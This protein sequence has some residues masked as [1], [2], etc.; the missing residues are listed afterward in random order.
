M[1]L[2]IS[3]YMVKDYSNA[4]DPR[5]QS[6]IDASFTHRIA[7]P[8][9][10]HQNERI[11]LSTEEMVEVRE[12][13]CGLIFLR[14][15]WARLGFISSATIVD[16]GFR[17]SLTMSLFNSAGHSIRI[18]PRESIWALVILPV[19]EESLLLYAGRYQ[20]QMELQLPKAIE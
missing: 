6:S 4:V 2:H 18:R 19:L 15:T 3:S 8:Y 7:L 13:T 17:G 12:G 16:P 11:I 10:V 5:A 20:G 9:E 14:S 1:D